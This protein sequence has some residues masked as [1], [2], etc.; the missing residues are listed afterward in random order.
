ML[1]AL[2]YLRADPAEI[3][4]DFVLG[5]TEIDAV[6]ERVPDADEAA[7]RA[8]VT[9]WLEECRSLL[10]AVRSR[11]LPEADVV[12][13]NLRHPDATS[14]QS[15]T[16]RPIQ[17][18]PSVFTRR[19]M[20]E[21]YREDR[22]PGARYVARGKPAPRRWRP[23]AQAT[24]TGWNTSRTARLVSVSSPKASTCPVYCA[25]LPGTRQRRRPL[26][27]CRRER[28]RVASRSL[29]AQVLTRARRPP[30]SRR[31]HRDRPGCHSGTWAWNSSRS[32]VRWAVPVVSRAAPSAT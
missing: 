30:T 27:Q 23:R 31:R 6:P 16:T 14:V 26:W 9:R 5:W 10:V 3:A 17:L 8:F 19:P 11:V 18:S 21:R 24:R 32:L 22:L 12:I 20:L 28:G 7:N 15:L 1:V 2:R 13:M 4:D 29:R 25:M